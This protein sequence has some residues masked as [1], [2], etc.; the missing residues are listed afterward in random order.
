M[1]HVEQVPA[2]G[3]RGWVDANHGQVVDVREPHEWALGTLPD[4]ERISMG[5][6]PHLMN[7]LDKRHPVLVVC[8]TGARSNQ[9]AMAMARAGFPKVANL[10]GGMAA[11]GMA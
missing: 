9:A 8:R 1:D 2:P 7:S 3:W 6:L 10:A 5:S 11:L 4:A